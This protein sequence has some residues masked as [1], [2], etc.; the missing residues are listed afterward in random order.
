LGPR[1]LPPPLLRAEPVHPPRSGPSPR[2]LGPG[3]RL[4]RGALV[5]GGLG[6]LEA[7]GPYRRRGPLRAAAQRAL[8]PPAGQPQPDAPARPPPAP[9]ARSPSGFRR[10]ALWGT[11]QAGPAPRRPEGP[12]RFALLLSRPHRP[13][14]RRR[15]GPPGAARPLGVPLPGV[16][17]PAG[18]RRRGG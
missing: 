12:L 13:G 3:R 2:A 1:A 6:L 15:R 4:R 11:A 5:P 17:R 7:P 18:G 8:P 10:P 16:L 9:T 14:L